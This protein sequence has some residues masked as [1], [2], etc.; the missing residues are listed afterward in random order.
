MPF[1]YFHLHGM[2]PIIYEGK[3]VFYWY[4]LSR[5]PLLNDH[6]IW[7]EHAYRVAERTFRNGIF[8]IRIEKCIF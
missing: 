5:I 3:V 1:A 4:D 6:M 8:Q 2:I 7:H